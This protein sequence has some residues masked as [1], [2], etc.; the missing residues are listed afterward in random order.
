MQ[1]IH[2]PVHLV[3]MLYYSVTLKEKGRERKVKKNPRMRTV[4]V[5]RDMSK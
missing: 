3:K 2:S 1:N 5:K 4:N